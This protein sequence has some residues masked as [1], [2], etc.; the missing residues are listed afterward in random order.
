MENIVDQLDQDLSRFKKPAMAMV[1]GIAAALV[2]ATLPSV[3][4]EKVIGMTG[5]AEIVPAAAPPLGNTAKSLLAIFAGLVSTS[6][7]FYFLHRK[8]DADMGLAIRKLANW[9]EEKAEWEER[10]TKPAKGKFSLKRLLQKPKKKKSEVKD[11]SDLPNLREKDSHPDAPARQPIF[12]EKD[13]G[14]AL[15]AKIQPFDRKEADPEAIDAE[16]VETKP[17]VAPAPFVMDK[18]LKSPE[19]QHQEQEMPLDLSGQISA[20][21]VM[22][23]DPPVAAVPE[24]NAEMVVEPESS[25]PSPAHGAPESAVQVTP[26]TS[27]PV[28]AA[29]APFAAPQAEMVEQPKEDLSGLSIAQLTERLEAGLNKLS[30]LQQ[31]IQQPVSAPAPVQ[32]IAPA[33]DGFDISSSEAAPS[34]PPVLK[35]V[36]PTKEEM[37]AKR[38]ADMDA[39]LKAALGTLEKMTAQR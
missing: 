31:S 5:L 38:Q 20:P 25:I 24:V 11:L 17:E 12:A 21:P 30:Q 14:A 2:V 10:K 18:S 36:E 16:H 23:A 22:E 32:N 29:P 8:G 6:V 27:E 3:Y 34:A 33:T 39:A 35:S 26:E 19:Q 1:G 4:L 9:E 28:A 13:L 15:N 37:E 7:V